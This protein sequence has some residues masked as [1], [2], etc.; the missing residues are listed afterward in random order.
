[1]TQGRAGDRTAPGHGSAVLVDVGDD[2][3]A[4]REHECTPDDDSQNDGDLL[5]PLGPVV[6]TEDGQKCDDDQT[7]DQQRPDAQDEPERRPLQPVSAGLDA[8]PDA[9]VRL[10][11]L[12]GCLH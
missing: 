1:M 8:T 9:I 12:V 4:N 5:E 7:E 3:I 10:G 11:A 6:G 2:G